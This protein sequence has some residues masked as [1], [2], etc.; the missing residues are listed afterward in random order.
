M[1][2]VT[3]SLHQFPSHSTIRNACPHS[4]D[5][6]SV[7]LALNGTEDQRRNQIL[8]E[9]EIDPEIEL[10]I[11]INFLRNSLFLLSFHGLILFLVTFGVRR[12]TGF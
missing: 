12:V 5:E 6:V 2:F 11:I 7:E 1:Q 9:I 4:F 8:I 10:H 3:L